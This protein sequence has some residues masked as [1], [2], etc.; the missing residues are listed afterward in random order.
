MVISSFVVDLVY[1]QGMVAYPLQEAVQILAFLIPWRVL[2][3]ANSES[4]IHIYTPYIY[5]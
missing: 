5:I 1:I 3:V 4:Y 2:R